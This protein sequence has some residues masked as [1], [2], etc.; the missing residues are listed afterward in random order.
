MVLTSSA[1][2]D[3]LDIYHGGDKDHP[4]TFGVLRQNSL[5]RGDNLSASAARVWTHS[6]CPPF[7]VV[8]CYIYSV[9][10]QPGGT[11]GRARRLAAVT[12]GPVAAVAAVV[13]VGG[14]GSA[15]GIGYCDLACCAAARGREAR[16]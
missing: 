3:R 1:K 11:W 10:H 14:L 6:G 13:A 7:F 8:R 9:G 16:Q 2:K 4:N 5:N 15:G 12:G